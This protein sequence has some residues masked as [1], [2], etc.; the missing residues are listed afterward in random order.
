MMTSPTAS[1]SVISWSNTAAK[2]KE[3]NQTRTACYLTLATLALVAITS[4]SVHTMQYMDGTGSLYKHNN[5]YQSNQF[6]V[7]QSKN[8]LRSLE[9]EN[10]DGNADDDNN[11]S[12]YTC[13]D[14]FALTE[15]NSEERCYFAQTCNSN[16]GLM[17]SFIF[18]NTYDLSTLSWVLIL[19]PFLTIWLILLFRMLGSTAEDFFSPSLEMFSMKM[20][21]PPRFAGVTLLALGNGAADVSATISAI[22][23]NPAKGYQMSLGALTGAGMFVGTVVAG[24]V[25]VV[26]D[27]VK[28]RGA[29]VRDIVMFI[30][31]LWAVYSFF[32][33]GVIGS[34]AVH[35]FL[36]MY[37]GF[38]V[39]V[40][41]ADIY[42]RKVVLPRMRKLEE[43]R[44]ELQ[45]REEEEEEE[46]NILTE[47]A[48]NQDQNNFLETELNSI[49]DTTDGSENGLSTDEELT[50]KS[51]HEKRVMFKTSE[52]ERDTNTT[53]TKASDGQL[54]SSA[55][56][57]SDSPNHTHQ[58]SNVELFMDNPDEKN[59]AT[60]GDDDDEGQLK[61]KKKKF[62]RRPKLGKKKKK[63][64]GK[65]TRTMVA[66]V[67]TIMMALSNYA[68]DEGDPNAKQS[69][70]GWSEGLEVTSES[71]DKPVKL[72]GT[73]GILSKK[74]STE[75]DIFED[76]EN[77]SENIGGPT[78]SYRMILENVDNLCTIDGSTSS[79]MNISWGNS[80]S[81]GWDDLVE[82]FSDYCKGIFTN[83]EN[84]FFDK[85]MLVCE[86][87]FT[88]LRKLSI[89]IP[90]DDYYC[91]GLIAASIALAPLWFGVYFL[92]EKGSNL[93]FSGGFPV[94]ELI[95]IFALLVAILVLKF[96]PE[97][98]KD[99]SLT[100]S[101]PIAFVGFIIAAT[102]IDTIAD[103]LVRLLTL[104]GVICRIPG[105]IMGITVLAWGNS[106]GDLSANMTMAKKGLANMAIT[107]CFAG[108]V[109]NIL[110]GLG[111]GFAK[112]NASSDEG[113]TE[114]EM[115]APITVGFVFLLSNCILVLIGGL[116]WNRGHIPAGY[117]YIA[118]VLYVVYVVVSIWLQ[119]AGGGDEE[120]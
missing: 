39:V 55:L 23:Q 104:L 26:A 17:F 49:N 9:E 116:V 35:T 10:D 96:S 1:S 111:G 2:R 8:P 110:I 57:A 99:M 77:S 98:E 7:K 51:S 105:S 15:V 34:G 28:C 12:E 76:E 88:I 11:Y 82:H 65:V 90:C 6:E 115:P 46:E 95:T 93:F 69:F 22:V 74:S 13:D 97:E 36:W 113:Y 114:V 89:P 47:E 84:G 71:M 91:R 85:L 92:I 79:G 29:L 94:I 118:L 42:H 44:M 37:F 38:I 54:Q 120:E 18:C 40:L 45:R 108:P 14:I 16:Q 31:T 119:F 60:S 102:W 61:K 30:I 48:E 72:R 24:I 3:T 107:A 21:L 67:D 73:N 25:I 62:L 83:E 87:P 33:T 86:L 68:P 66:G 19:S 117:G 27:G 58:E 20:G 63:K 56:T 75:T 53:S 103:L 109:F 106:M 81:S 5:S 100:V 52:D 4:L 78:A 50:D 70:K 64:K 112:L 32:E 43:S 59:Y 80:L 101:V 41:L